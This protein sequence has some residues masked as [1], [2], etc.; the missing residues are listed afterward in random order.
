MGEDLRGPRR[1]AQV[2]ARPE[3]VSSYL[4]PLLCMPSLVHLS[5][6]GKVLGVARRGGAV[7]VGRMAVGWEWCRGG[8]CV[9]RRSMLDWLGG[10]ASDIVGEYFGDARAC[11]SRVC[12][13]SSGGAHEPGM[14]SNECGHIAPYRVG[15][16]LMCNCALGEFMLCGCMLFSV[17]P[18]SLLR[19]SGQ[20]S[21][22]VSVMSAVCQFN[23]T[24]VEYAAHPF[25]SA[26][27]PIYP[28]FNH[29][30]TLRYR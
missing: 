27:V 4:V 25:M 9:C 30:C 6:W 19:Y 2:K 23:Y 16:S 22:T 11:G 17:P 10:R 21:A 26:H 14:V 20:A 3:C 29:R 18:I 15:S 12:V 13:R 5:V 24:L 8:P 7:E 28:P 1:L